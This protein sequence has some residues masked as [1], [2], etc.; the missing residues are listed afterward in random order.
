MYFE[1]NFE[2]IEDKGYVKEQ[3]LESFKAGRPVYTMDDHISLCK[4]ILSLFD[5]NVEPFIV[6]SVL[7]LRCSLSFCVIRKIAI[8][9]TIMRSYKNS[10]IV[11]SYII[12]HVHLLV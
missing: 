11:W 2:F 12:Y 7:Y 1:A 4:L 6:V 8:F 9:I 10:R 5:I 3:D